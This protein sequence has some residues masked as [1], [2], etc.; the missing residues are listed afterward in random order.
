M[1]GKELTEEEIKLFLNKIRENVKKYYIDFYP[2]DT[3]YVVRHPWDARKVSYLTD[4]WCI[5]SGLVGTVTLDKYGVSY[6]PYTLSGFKTEDVGNTIFLRKEDAFD[7]LDE[8]VGYKTDH[9]LEKNYEVKK[10]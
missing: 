3:F 8:I 6:T 10:V 7:K 1:M 2:G 4:K 5:H 9:E